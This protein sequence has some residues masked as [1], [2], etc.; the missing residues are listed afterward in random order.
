MEP[1]Y[2]DRMSGSGL[3]MRVLYA[4]VATPVAAIGGF[5]VSVLLLTRGVPALEG[6]PSG[7][8]GWAEFILSLLVASAVGFTVFCYALTLPWRRLR[9]RRGRPLRIVVSAMLV[10]LVSVIAAA[11]AVPMSYVA[12]L[13]IWMSLVLTFTLIR[14]G[15]RD[16]ITSGA[17]E[18]AVVRA[19]SS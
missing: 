1:Y 16:R 9:R 8:P 13:M 5:Y 15:V 7:D 10:L 3:P 2:A 12:G 19:A 11:E 18:S 17:A 4:T 14:Y 6:A